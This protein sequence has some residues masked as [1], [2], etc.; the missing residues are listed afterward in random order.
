MI[1]WITTKRHYKAPALGILM[2]VSGLA[3]ATFAGGE[4]QKR[5][6]VIIVLQEGVEPDSAAAD[7]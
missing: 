6:P 1:G 2:A 4:G 7:Q 3:A 5:V